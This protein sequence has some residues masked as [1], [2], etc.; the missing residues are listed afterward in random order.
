MKNKMIFISDLTYLFIDSDTGVDIA[1][2]DIDPTK[3]ISEIDLSDDCRNAIQEMGIEAISDLIAKTESELLE[4]D[5]FTQ[6]YVDEIINQ[7]NA[8]GLKLH[9]GNN[10]GE[11]F[12]V[13]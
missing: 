8:L 5:G 13:I 12:D 2:D 3:K 4:Q 1:T 9:N 11:V 10:V 6:A 7:L